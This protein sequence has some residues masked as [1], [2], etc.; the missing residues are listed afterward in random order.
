[1]KKFFGEKWLFLVLII[2]GVFLMHNLCFERGCFFKNFSRPMSCKYQEYLVQKEVKRKPEMEAN[3]LNQ[4]EVWVYDGVGN[5]YRNIPPTEYYLDFYVQLYRDYG[6]I[7]FGNCFDESFYGGHYYDNVYWKMFGGS[8]EGNSKSPLD[9]RVLENGFCYFYISL[10]DPPWY[11]P[12]QYEGEVFP[13]SGFQESGIPKRELGQSQYPLLDLQVSLGSYKNEYLR[14]PLKVDVV[15]FDPELGIP[16]KLGA[17]GPHVF[18]L[19]IPK[20]S[21]PELC[22]AGQGGIQ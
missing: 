4:G 5:R 11:I 14:I 8:I 18:R 10:L 22:G 7:V 2:F 17:S 16:T 20:I 6:F 19:E 21:K 1:M 12:M 3:R 9:K 13:P 15:K